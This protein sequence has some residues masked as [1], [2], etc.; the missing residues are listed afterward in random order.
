MSAEN[1]LEEFL[2][3]EKNDL[4]AVAEKY[5]AEM[6]RIY[7]MKHPVSAVP[8][9]DKMK[10]HIDDAVISAGE[11]NNAEVTEDLRCENCGTA[12]ENE[13]FMFPPMPDIP[14]KENNNAP[15]KSNYGTFDN[16]AAGSKE[17][18]RFPSADELI[19]MDCGDEESVPAMSD[20]YTEDLT[21]EMRFESSS[22]DGHMQ[23]NYGS[24]KDDEGLSADCNNSIDNVNDTCGA[25]CSG[26]GHGYLQAEV[27]QS[28]NGSPVAGA[29]VAVLKKVWD[30]DMLVTMLVTDSNGMTEAVE[31]DVSGTENK[32]RPYDEYMVTVY[33]EGFYTVD[34]L[35][36]PIFDTIKSIQ[37]VE[38]NKAE[39]K[40]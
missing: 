4:G 8:E 15:E 32:A 29:F 39:E 22:S 24:Y 2:M 5:K 30:S 35:P 21:P 7:N 17:K 6:M 11:K 34:M 3:Q 25:F 1:Y 23:G 38:M 37:P 18:C 26:T 9:P 36:V 14:C 19:K 27:T 10:M 13:K 12:K 20:G 40:C 31:L 28:G 16:D 33:K